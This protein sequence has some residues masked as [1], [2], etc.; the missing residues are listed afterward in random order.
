[1]EIEKKPTIIRV[2]KLLQSS[3]LTKIMLEAALHV[4]GIQWNNV[5]ILYNI[6]F[7]FSFILI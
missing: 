6:G 5:K 7:L 1:M 4:Q 3:I 2:R